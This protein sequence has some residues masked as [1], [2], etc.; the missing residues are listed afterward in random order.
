MK[1]VSKAAHAGLSPLIPAVLALPEV[2]V[3]A[4]PGFIP[5]PLN[6]TGVRL[7]TKELAPGVYGL[8]SNRL[9]VDNSGF[10]VGERG[11]LVIDAHINGAMAGQI[12]TAVRQ[13]TDK[14][15]L[16]VVNTNYHGD[17]TFGNYA[18]PASVEIIAHRKTRDSMEDLA[19]EKRIRTRNL[20]GNDAAITDVVTW[21]K[22]DRV[23]DGESMELDL[24]DRKGSA[25][26]FRSRQHPR[27]HHRLRARGEGSVDGKFPVQ[28]VNRQH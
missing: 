1:G 10:V 21:R 4:P 18:F 2:M 25:L 11:V 24:G 16:Y 22:P 23:F 20:Y 5:P 14:P 6:P 8:L 17:H 3:L 15:L 12:Q 28:R 7:E 9:P 26:A 13:V 19:A 27:R